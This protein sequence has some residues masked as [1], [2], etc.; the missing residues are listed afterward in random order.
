MGV[1]LPA[2]QF[3]AKKIEVITHAGPGG[4]T[5]ITTRVMMIGGRKELGV[6]MVLV[7]KRGGA[8]A[9]SLNYLKSRP[10]DG[11]TLMTMTP[12]HL[13]TM[14]RGKSSIAIDD[15]VG[16]ARAT[17]DPQIIMVAAD[18]PY[19]SVEDLIRASRDKGLKWGITQI[20][21]IDHITAYSFSR[22]A[23]IKLDVVPFRGG[24]DVLTNL[25]GQN[26]QVALLNLG[27]AEIQIQSGKIRPLLVLA[28]ERMNRLPEVPTSIEKG[29]DA[30]FS[31]VRG[32]VALK[33]VPESSLAELEKKI[34]AAMGHDEF[35][36]HLKASGLGPGSVVDR[37]EWEAQFRQLYQDGLE[38]LRELGFVR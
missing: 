34:I 21:S 1:H 11:H 16:I 7:N 32:F 38:S 25:L 10:R 33:G 29:I 22:K 15:L 12:T 3:P 23:G 4:G 24:G 6:D 30:V 18:S 28:K 31:V 13:F 19:G 2:E 5:D 17:D 26:V 20:G 27:E 37:K 14:A 35:Q 8:G 9:L 36:N